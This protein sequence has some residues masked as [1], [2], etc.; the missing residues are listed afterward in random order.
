MATQVVE[1]EK[2][3]V[4]IDIET[5]I[6]QDDTVASEITMMMMITKIV[7]EDEEEA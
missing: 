5:M 7:A 3:I 2:M 6:E 4:E 1:A